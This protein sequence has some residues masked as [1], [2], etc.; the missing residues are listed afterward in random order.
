[1]LFA[2]KDR[3]VFLMVEHIYLALVKH[4]PH[5]EVTRLQSLRSPSSSR[6][7]IDW[8]ANKRRPGL[9]FSATKRLS[10][11]EMSVKYPENFA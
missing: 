1:M 3:P 11:G 8:N 6:L 9:L 4:L 2:F 7:S 10:V 5:R